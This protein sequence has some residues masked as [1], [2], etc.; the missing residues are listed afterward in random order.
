MEQQ[1]KLICGPGFHTNIYL[2][3]WVIEVTM[4]LAN[5][6]ADP[7]FSSLWTLQEASYRPML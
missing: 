7:W 2:R 5:F 4:I 1:F 6:L 3:N